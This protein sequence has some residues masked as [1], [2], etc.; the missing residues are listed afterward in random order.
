MSCCRTFAHPIKHQNIALSATHRFSE[1][2]RVDLM[3]FDREYHCR[4]GESLIP[5]P[6]PIGH[7]TLQQLAD[8]NIAHLIETFGLEFISQHNDQLTKD[9]A[10][11]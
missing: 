11:L 7:H 5:D 4:P 8:Q 6:I 1:A 2:E 9:D 10:V 3:R